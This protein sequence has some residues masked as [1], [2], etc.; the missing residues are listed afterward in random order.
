MRKRQSTAPVKLFSHSDPKVEREMAN[1]Y[2]FLSRLDVGPFTFRYDGENRK[3]YVSVFDD[4]S[5]QLESVAEIDA[6]TKDVR[7]AG[8]LAQSQTLPQYA[9]G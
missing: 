2:A 5:Q 9:R 3:L 6:Q 1:I 4:S 8:T 7:L